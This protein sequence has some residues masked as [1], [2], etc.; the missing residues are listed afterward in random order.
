VSPLRP[1]ANPPNPWATTDVEYLDGEAPPAQL[2]V[3]E[4]HSRSILAHNDSPDVGFSWSVNPYRGCFHACAY[5]LAGET[6]ILMTDGTTRELRA[7]C[8]GDAIYGTRFD[9]KYRRLVSTTVLARW[10]T[11]KPAVRMRLQDGTT[12]VA[13]GDHR[14]LTRRGWKHVTDAPGQR[15]HLT[16]ANR[17][18]GVGPFARAPDDTADY[19]RGYLCGLL[20]GDAL[21][22]VFRYERPGRAQGDQYQFRLALVDLEPLVRARRYLLEMG[23]ETREFA[24]AAARPNRRAM[25]GIRTHARSNVERVQA[26][27]AWP[28]DAPTDWAKG[29]LAG[30]FDAEGSFSGGILRI[31]NTDERMLGE[32]MRCMARLHFDAVLEERAPQASNVRLRGGMREHIRFF[33]A[34]GPAIR[35]KRSVEGRALK[36]STSPRVASIEPLGV[37][38]PMF[39][40]TTGTGDFIAEG[41][42]AHNCYARPGHEYLSFGAGTDFDRKIVVKPRAPALLRDAFDAP[43][44]KGENVVFSG[45]TDCYQPLEASYR[46]TRGCLEVCAEYRNPCGIISKSPLVERDVDVFQELGR[47]TRFTMMVSCPFWDEAK[48]RAIEPFV[49]TPARRIRVIERLAKAGVDVGVMVAPIIPGLNDEDMGEVLRAAKDAGATRAGYVLLRL[50]GPVAE[51]FPL[52]LKAAL[53]LRAEKVMRRIRE[54]RGGKMYDPRFG[55]RGTGEGPYAEA[56]GRLFEQTCA[57]LGLSTGPRYEAGGDAPTTFR[58]PTAQTSLF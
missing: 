54:A 4:D 9:G 24:F 11:V 27:C 21:L 55:V 20:R 57:K 39:D 19:R 30:I 35:R 16:S 48:A 43:K 36:S 5:C 13:S 22:K 53:P 50:P 8:T 46:I 14:F 32:T 31:S 37:D 33:Q 41:V 2:E 51:V 42:V 28:E 3:F 58:R 40:I 17:L 38:V 15:P 6:R 34:T 12:L 10:Q 49:T 25:S 47:V 23:V 52:R 56:I 45:V 44:W 18:L 7:L 1:L 26:I 29:F